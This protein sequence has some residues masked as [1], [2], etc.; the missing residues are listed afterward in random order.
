MIINKLTLS[1][2]RQ[3]YGIQNI[4]LVTNNRA[5]NVIV[6]YGSNGRGKTG[7]YRALM[8]CL[9]GE[10][11]LSQDPEDSKE[12]HLVNEIALDNAKESNSEVE[13]YVEVDFVHNN[14]GYKLKRSVIGIKTNDGTYEQMGRVILTYKDEDGNSKVVTDQDEI[15]SNISSILD[16]RLREYFLFDGE[17]IERL[18]RATREQKKEVQ[19][20]IKN[21]LNID[22]LFVAGDALNLLLKSLEKQLKSKSTG[23]YKKLLIE[24]EEKES[25]LDDLKSSKDEMEKEYDNADGVLKDI[26]TQLKRYEGIS[27]LLKERDDIQIK[28]QDAVKERKELCE[29]MITTN[30]DI[31]LLLIEPELAN[32]E[33]ILK[34]KIDN[35][36]LPSQIRESVVEK[37]LSDNI[38]ICGAKIAAGTAAQRAIMEWKNKVIDAQIEQGLMETYKDIGATRERIKHRAE[39]VENSLQEFAVKTEYIEN[40]EQKLTQISDA[41]GGQTINENIPRLEVDR[42]TISK[43][44]IQLEV[45]IDNI[46]KK[47]DECG[48]VIKST[49]LKIKDKERHEGLRNNLIRRCDIISASKEALLTI[50][51]EFVEEIKN[52]ISEYA[53]LIFHKLIDDEGKKIFKN[54]KVGDDYSLQIYDWRAK[55]FLANI[56]AG[57]RQITS[58]SFITALAQLAGD[59]D[60]LEMPL[61]MDTP[62]GRLSGEHRDNIIEYI[63]GLTRQWILLATDTE[64]GSQEA[65]KLRATGNWGKVY[66]LESNKPYFTEIKEKS[67]DT[68]VPVRSS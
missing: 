17:R 60:V 16:K 29:L 38:C 26:E 20:G 40:Y 13:T 25:I 45:K 33:C 6:I 56:S 64:F 41:I 50:Q 34:T 7:L 51:N 53:T 59:E 9:Y 43:K 55:P 1:N 18:T 52:K 21:L 22:R 39:Q 3:F 57:Q 66:V 15:E 19:I 65:K 48:D 12:I 49:R 11:R 31:G 46:L 35:H 37:I 54:I 63:P 47:I 42:K 27:Q 4:E 68:F 62:F 36:E 58:I 10:M 24:L 28:Y 23:E 5:Q 32:V 8:F 2:F 30:D 44:K 61:F 14:R 67:V